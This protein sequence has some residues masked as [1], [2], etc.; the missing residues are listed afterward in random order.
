MAV[1]LSLSDVPDITPYIQYVATSGQTVFPYP[2][3]ITQDS[4]LIAI[5]GGVTL[6]TDA[7]YTLSGQG[8]DTGGNLT[9]AVGLTTGTVLTLFRDIPIERL[10]EIGQ[11]SGFSSEG[12]NF[13][14]NNIYLIMQQL[15]A[16]INLSLRIP[17]T[18]NPAPTTELLPANYANKYLGFD[19]NGN[20]TPV[21]LTSSGAITQAILTALINPQTPAE[22]AVGVVPVQL[23]YSA[24]IVDRYAVNTVPGTTDMSTAFSNCIAANQASTM[25]SAQYFTSATVTV[26]SGK[27][28]FGT[29]LINPSSASPLA[30]G[31]IV[32]GAL[33]LA[34]VVQIGSG[35]AIG[36]AAK[37]FG[38]TRAAGTP[39][40]G[41]IGLRLYKGVGTSCRDLFS[42]S[43]QICIRHDGDGAGLGHFMDHINTAAAYDAHIVMDTLPEIR[44]SNSRIGSNGTLDQPCNTYVR[45][46]GGDGALPAAGP[47]TIVFS[48]TQFNSGNPGS[49]PTN[50]LQFVNLNAP[51][52]PTIDARV[53]S[54]N[55][56]CHI[57]GVSTALI[58]ADASWAAADRLD[59]IGCTFNTSAI[60]FF[61]LPATGF[62]IN[63]W[64]FEGNHIGC[65]TFAPNVAVVNSLMVTGNAFEAGAVT[66]NSGTTGG[67]NMASVGNTYA[68]GASR[69][70]S[71]TKWVSGIFVDSF[72]TGSTSTITGTPSAALTIIDPGKSVVAWTPTLQFGGASAGSYTIQSAGMQV[73]GNMVYY[74]FRLK[75]NVKSG[76]VGVATIGGMP[77]P[78]NTGL[79]QLGAVGI[80]AGLNNMVGLTAPIIAQGP[81]GGSNN[82]SLLVQGA[83]ATAGI[84]DTNFS[85]GSE[86][87][88]AIT[89]FL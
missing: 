13:E 3:P 75:L 67:W 73:T 87:A 60:P 5:V 68:A 45:I 76:N 34:A 15:E 49:Q 26:T 48:N 19:A 51:G 44:Y 27:G 63:G 57:E 33:S 83:A 72:N 20:P 59:I 69:T 18:N 71:G 23:V 8:N 2:F 58:K 89:F 65:L 40:A 1:P 21:A 42:W 78:F 28:L 11:N 85:N 74:Q 55:S 17:N 64:R 37:G 46:T 14:F 7:G 79:F 6:A 32:V 47:N 41:A 10:T 22:A 88:G 77:I 24:G 4:D 56:G 12:F 62:A 9:F 82:I 31:S 66:Y 52:V 81:I 39:P 38:I 36:S 43:H 86:I 53:F 16:D 29:G 80:V 50:W 84:N 70:I 61:D 54:F 30:F 35:G 25:L